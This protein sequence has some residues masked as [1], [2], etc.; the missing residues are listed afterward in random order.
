MKK[1]YRIKKNKEFQ[2]VFKYGKS[3][4]NRQLVLYY[5]EKKEQ[6][7]FRIGLSVSKKIGNAVVR[8]QVKRYLR[9]AFYE[10]EDRIIGH[11]DLVVIARMPAKDMNFHEVKNSL[12]HLLTKTKLLSKE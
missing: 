5:K 1:V 6:Q 8:N 4:A 3:F 11:Y 7:H 2:V 10:V 12:V 9:Q